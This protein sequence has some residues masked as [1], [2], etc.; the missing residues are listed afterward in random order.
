MSDRER[1][2]VYPLLFLALGV[3][4]RD[5]LTQS[6]D[7]LRFLVGN[8]VSIDLEDGL[9]QTRELQAEVVHCRIL[10]VLSEMGRPLVELDGVSLAVGEGHVSGAIRV[11]D[12][13]G[14]TLLVLRGGTRR[15]GQSSSARRSSP[16]T[17]KLGEQG[18]IEVF[19]GQQTASLRLGQHQG[20][21]GLFA[22][23]RTGDGELQSEIITDQE[24]TPNESPPIQP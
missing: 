11:A 21:T 7:D 16:V 24:S 6:I 8:A 17:A 15:P 20:K 18:V 23:R 13:E 9:I 4:L 19:D 1:W 2:I 10:K 14:Q 12:E 5:K 22:N 3:S